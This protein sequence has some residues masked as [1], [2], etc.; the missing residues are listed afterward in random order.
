MAVRRRSINRSVATVVWAG[1]VGHVSLACSITLKH[2]ERN[3][4]CVHRTDLRHWR[5]ARI[6]ATVERRLEQLEGH[7]A[8]MKTNTLVPSNPRT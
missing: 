3:W 6:G 2:N 5:L 1:R 8:V 7:R 4:S